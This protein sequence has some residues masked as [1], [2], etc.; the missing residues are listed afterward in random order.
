MTRSLLLPTGRH[1]V[2][3]DDG[4]MWQASGLVKM[5]LRGLCDPYVTL[6]ITNSDGVGGK[7]K[8]TKF[9][10]QNLNP[11][12]NEQFTFPVFSAAQILVV[13][14]KAAAPRLDLRKDLRS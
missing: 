11:E 1:V 2:A 13:S 14:L 12:F 10:R 3:S 9:I 7:T 5:D 8:R 4:C 6:S